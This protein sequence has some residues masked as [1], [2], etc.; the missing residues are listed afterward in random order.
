MEEVLRLAISEVVNKLGYGFNENIY[1]E[2]L[3]YVL[4]G[5]GYNIKTQVKRDVYFDNKELLGSVRLDMII[6]EGKA[7]VEMKST[8]NS[9]STK[10][11]NQVK[12]YKKVTE[13]EEAYIVFVSDCHSGA[14]R[15]L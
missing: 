14:F 6:D 11:I 8:S 1:E 12:A 10:D 5:K 9:L 7:I 3:A 13:V 15:V 2:P 4:R